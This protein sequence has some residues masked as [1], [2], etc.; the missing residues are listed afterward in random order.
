[1]NRPFLA[2]I[3]RLERLHS[4]TTA[5]LTVETLEIRASIEHHNVLHLQLGP[6]TGQHLQF[7]HRARDLYGLAHGAHQSALHLLEADAVANQL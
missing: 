4:A 3:S 5:A 7:H 1:M 6:N 2:T